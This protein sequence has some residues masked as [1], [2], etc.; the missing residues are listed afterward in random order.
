MTP[1]CSRRPSRSPGV[2]HAGRPGGGVHSCPL[3]CPLPEAGHSSTCGRTCETQRAPGCRSAR[4][5]SPVTLR[6]QDCSLGTAARG[7]HGGRAKAGRMR[8][9]CDRGTEDVPRVAQV[10]RLP[11]TLPEPGGPHPLCPGSHCAPRPMSE[12]S[13]DR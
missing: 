6:L 8:Q 9:R 5:P 10:R 2:N 4:E 11:R 12:R 7:H 1:D 3:H 13:P